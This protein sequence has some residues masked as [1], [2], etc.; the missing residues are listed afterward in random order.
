MLV[1]VNSID[2]DK[3]KVKVTQLDIDDH[4]SLIPLKVLELCISANDDSIIQILK[5]H[6]YACIFT[7]DNIDDNNSTIIL[8]NGMTMDEL[9]KEKSRTKDK[10]MCERHLL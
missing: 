9:N 8:A 1:K 5:N 6:S 10:C 3:N 7:E 4:G 2:T